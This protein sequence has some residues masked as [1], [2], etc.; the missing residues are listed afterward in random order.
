MRIEW[1]ETFLVVIRISA[2]VHVITGDTPGD[3]C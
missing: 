3:S 2:E 1:S